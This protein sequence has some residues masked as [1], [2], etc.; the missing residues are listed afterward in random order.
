MLLLVDLPHHIQA[1]TLGLVE[2]PA[3]SQDRPAALLLQEVK[4]SLKISAY[5][6]KNDK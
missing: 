2:H 6:E 4:D 3:Q 1:V 5:T